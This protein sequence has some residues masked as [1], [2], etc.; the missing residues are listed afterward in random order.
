MY[1]RYGYR[2]EQQAVLAPVRGAHVRQIRYLGGTT[3]SA[4]TGKERSCSID[5]VPYLGGTTGSAGT[6][7]ERSSTVDTV[8]G[9]NNRQCWHR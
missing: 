6:G 9:R 8:P 7:K 3:G 2:A 5:T 1:D 4:G